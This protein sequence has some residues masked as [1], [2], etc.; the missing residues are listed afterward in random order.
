MARTKQ[1][2]RKS[3]GGKAPRKQL[4]TKAARN[5]IPAL[6]SGGCGRFGIKKPR[7]YRPGIV[8]LREIRK[9]QKTT[10]LLIRKL[11]FHRLVRE[12][13]YSYKTDLHFQSLAMIALQEACEVNSYS[14]DS[15][16]LLHVFFPLMHPQL[17]MIMTPPRAA[18]LS[19]PLPLP[20]PL[21]YILYS[22]QLPLVRLYVSD[23]ESA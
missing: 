16:W 19:H 1:T 18:G 15:A 20:P 21:Y 9:Y 7:R 4:T 13:A 6:D 11:P 3:I 5:S 23:A 17:Q 2:A 22:I 12:I 14:N 8:A 10:E